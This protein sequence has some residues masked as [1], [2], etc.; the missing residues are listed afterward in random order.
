MGRLR[1]R[2]LATGAATVAG[3]LLAE[4]LVRGRYGAPLPEHLPLMEVVAD[5]RLGWRMVPGQDHRTYAH[6]VRV[7]SLGLR[8]PEIPAEREPDELRVL[9]LGDST[10]Y[11]QGV[12][13]ED[14]LPAVIEATLGELAP[15]RR[16]RA[17]NAG[18]RG[19]ATNQELALLDEL[20]PRLDPDIVLLVWFE[21]DL[22]DIDI[23]RNHEQFARL[24]QVPFDTRDQLAGP[25]LWRW[26][27]VQLLRRSALLMEVHDRLL[28]R[29]GAPPAPGDIERGLQRAGEH[30]MD[31]ATRSQEHGWQAAVAVIPHEGALTTGSAHARIAARVLA[32][33]EQSGLPALDLL[34]ALAEF[35]ATT[36][37]S[38]LLPYDGHYSGAANR[39]MGRSAAQQLLEVV[40]L[41]R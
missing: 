16:W 23:P 20:G 29:K 30:L 15:D 25:S 40:D 5:P 3:L 33:A 17:I 21:N 24:G 22:E 4:A 7:N 28:D 35:A 38:T 13:E 6:E 11:G 19:Y 18:H 37:G 39:A 26:H 34:P 41:E 10:T 32:Q 9:V 31:L 1:R 36:G 14:T 8:G 27:G 12:A 2:L